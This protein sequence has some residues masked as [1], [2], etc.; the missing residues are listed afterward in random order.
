MA[1]T[2]GKRLFHIVFPGNRPLLRE[3]RAGTQAGRSD[4]EAVADAGAVK[5]LCLLAYSPKLIQ[6]AFFQHSE[7]SAHRWPGL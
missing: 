3:I 1:E 7:P 2:G 6:P 4:V 5:E